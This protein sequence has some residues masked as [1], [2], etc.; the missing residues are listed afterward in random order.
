MIRQNILFESH[1]TRLES[2]AII[3]IITGGHL[4]YHTARAL[5]DLESE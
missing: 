4:V 3:D 2:E 1:V 5:R